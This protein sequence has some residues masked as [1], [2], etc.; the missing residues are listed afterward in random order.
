MGTTWSVRLCPPPGTDRAQVRDAIQQELDEIIM[1]FS[2]WEPRSEVS[3]FNGAPPG[4]Y[5]VS[6]PFWQFLDGCMDLADQTDGAVDPTLGALVNLWG[7]GPPGPRPYDEAFKGPGEPTDEEVEAARALIGWNRLR[8][9]LKTHAVTQMGGMRF[10]FS[11]LAKG[12]AV[13]RISERLSTDGIESH[14]VEIGGELRGANVRPD[15]YPWWVEIAS[16]PE[17]GDRRTVAALFDMAVATSG[18]DVRF[19]Q[20]RNQRFSHT[21]DRRTGRPIT[22][23]MM[24]VTVFDPSAFRADGLATALTV[25]GPEL[26]PSYAE[27]LEIAAMFAWRNADGSVTERTT[28]ALRA[29]EEEGAGES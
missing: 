28:P 9:S 10:D 29:M 14:L 6:E 4:L 23:G 3:R 7:F 24:S 2:H 22:N 27:A 25:M 21:L 26:G 11:G 18:D 20:N 1:R 5:A 19:W 17:L 13:D 8:L 12:H 15:G 16:P